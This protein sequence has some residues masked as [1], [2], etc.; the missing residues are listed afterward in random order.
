[1]LLWAGA[2]ALGPP[3]GS[4]WPAGG[5]SVLEPGRP[6]GRALPAGAAAIVRSARPGASGPR[7]CPPWTPRGTGRGPA[8]ASGPGGPAEESGKCGARL[9]AGGPQAS[10][11]G[12]C[13]SRGLPRGVRP[14]GALAVRA[15]GACAERG[16]REDAGERACTARA[17]ADAVCGGFRHPS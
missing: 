4:F 15:A 9:A 3:R 6:L 11:P 2:L 16:S 13:W 8:R 7:R 10:G 5:F 12:P 14:G 1:M 17:G